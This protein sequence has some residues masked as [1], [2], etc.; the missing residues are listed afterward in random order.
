MLWHGDRVKNFLGGNEST[1]KLIVINAGIAQ[2]LRSSG[3]LALGC[4]PF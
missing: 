4:D 2:A 1:H 3:F